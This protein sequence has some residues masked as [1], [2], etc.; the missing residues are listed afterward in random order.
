MTSQGRFGT[1]TIDLQEYLYLK[2]FYQNADFG[3]AESDIRGMMEDR[4]EATTG[5]E[6]PDG[7]RDE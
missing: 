2:W 3:P 1:I 6:V 5:N 7:Y 4:Y